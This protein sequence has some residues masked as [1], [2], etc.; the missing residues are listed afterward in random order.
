ME[1]LVREYEIEVRIKGPYRNVAVQI[2]TYIESAVAEWQ[3]DHGQLTAGYY[4]TFTS[5]TDDEGGY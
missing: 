2:Q 5:T 4:A 1:A 3:K